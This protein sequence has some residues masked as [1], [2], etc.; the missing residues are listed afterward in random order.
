MIELE[1]SH[2][3]LI[4]LKKSFPK[5]EKSTERALKKYV[6]VLTK[7]L[8]QSQLMRHNGIQIKNLVVNQSRTIN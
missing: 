1:V 3:V 4:S 5:P 6:S 7:Q 2:K 8:N